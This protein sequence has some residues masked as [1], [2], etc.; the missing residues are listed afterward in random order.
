[1]KKKPSAVGTSIAGTA[2]EWQI[3]CHLAVRSSDTGLDCTLSL[4]NDCNKE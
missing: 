3:A 2:L 4:H 1:M